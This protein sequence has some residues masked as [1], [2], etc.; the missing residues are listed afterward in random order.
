MATSTTDVTV[1]AVFSNISTAKSAANELVSNGFSIGD[2]RIRSGETA[3]V[4]REAG[5]AKRHSAHSEKG[6]KAWFKALLGSEGN[7]EANTILAL[8]TTQQDAVRV[9]YALNRYPP[10]NVFGFR[11][12]SG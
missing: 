12:G 6:L 8:D 5:H 3:A 10:I 9:A 2:I 1:V 11:P 4:A 7:R